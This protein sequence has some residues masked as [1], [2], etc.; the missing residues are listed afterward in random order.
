MNT[1]GKENMNTCVTGSLESIDQM[2]TFIT[3][4]NDAEYQYSAAPWFDSSIGQHLRHIV[5][6]F[7][8]LKDRTDTENINYDIRR[9]GAAIETVRKVG[10]AELSDIRKWMTSITAI[11]I[12]QEISVS[13]EVALSSQQT[14]TFV[15]SFGRELCFA[16]SHLTHHLA[17]MAVIAKMAGK[18]VDPTLGLAPA[19]ATF[20][21][22]QEAIEKS[23]SEDESALCAR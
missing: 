7:L 18:K 8:A 17:I 3:D 9:R 23:V 19:T 12:N 16:S 4:L 15:S 11:D 20:V 5:D 1:N 21:R 10:L 6:L 22:E 2:I 13:T 14:E